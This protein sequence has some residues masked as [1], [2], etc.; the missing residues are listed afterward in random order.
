MSVPTVKPHP[1][2]LRR[3]QEALDL[4]AKITGCATLVLTVASVI[5][6]LITEVDRIGPR[7]APQHFEE[8][9]PARP[10]P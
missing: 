6:V 8:D 10:G 4:A 3:R 5:Y 7:T 2:R 1:A 9:A